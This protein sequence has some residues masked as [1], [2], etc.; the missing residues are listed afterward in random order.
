MP[1]NR[2]DLLGTACVSEERSFADTGLKLSLGKL[3]VSFWMGRSL[4]ISSGSPSSS[5]YRSSSPPIAGTNRTT[6][7]AILLSYTK[8][9]SGSAERST[10]S[11]ETRVLCRPQSHWP[12]DP[13]SLFLEIDPTSSSFES[14]PRSGCR[15][16]TRSVDQELSSTPPS[17]SPGWSLD[18]MPMRCIKRR[19]SWL[20]AHVP[21]CTC[22]L[23]RPARPSRC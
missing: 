15:E 13:A 3:C 22:V 8:T 11:H 14:G 23:V 4:T 17:G 20:P 12:Q 9:R 19:G 5:T 18:Q 16:E 7:S 1:L 21:R 6:S 10:R 2:K